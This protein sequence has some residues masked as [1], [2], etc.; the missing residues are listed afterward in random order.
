MNDKI[1]FCLIIKKNYLLF[2]IKNEQTQ[3]INILLIY[4]DPLVK[5]YV[6]WKTAG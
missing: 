3:C 6:T 1:I 4:Y 5:A 2:P